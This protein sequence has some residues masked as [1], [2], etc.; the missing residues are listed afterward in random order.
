VAI[1]AIKPVRM[2]GTSDCATSAIATLLGLDY[3]VIEAVAKRA[4]RRI[5]KRGMDSGEI[6]KVLKALGWS[7]STK[8][9]Y[10][11]EEETGLVVL[12]AGTTEHVIVAFNGSVFDPQEGVL[13]DPDGYLK[14]GWAFGVLW[15]V[16][17]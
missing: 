6:R 10:D 4:L 14:P 5:P 15:R 8:L 12:K 16:S 11:I 2:R 7:M 9:K 13:Y 17:R 3:E 1:T